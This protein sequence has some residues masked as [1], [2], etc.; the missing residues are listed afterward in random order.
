LITRDSNKVYFLCKTSQFERCLDDLR[1]KGGTATDAAERIDEILRNLMHTAD[2]PE[3]EQFRYTRNGEY[4]IKHCK[5][6]SLGCGYRLVFTQKDGCYV[7]LY[8]GSHDDCFRWIERNKGL[9]Y[10]LDWAANSM[11][12]VHTTDKDADELP[13][14]VLEEKIFVERYEKKL[15]AQIDDELLASIF[16]GW[17][18][19]DQD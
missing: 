10:E 3:R 16:T 15:M 6:I 11:S 19:S 9:T 18:N 1:K 8:A 14:D 2:R 13:E 7:F 12:I 4:R 5:K 17:R